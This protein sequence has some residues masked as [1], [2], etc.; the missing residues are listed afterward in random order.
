[1]PAEHRCCVENRLILEELLK[2]NV[3]LITRMERM[4]NMIMDGKTE[5]RK[6]VEVFP[7]RDVEALNAVGSRIENDPTFSNALVI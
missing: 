2:M 4:E 1:M 5:K 3:D 6:I 7:I